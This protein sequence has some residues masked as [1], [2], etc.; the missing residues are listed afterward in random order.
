MDQKKKKK[1]GEKKNKQKSR[2]SQKRVE[3]IALY[4]K[5]WAWMTS[6][7]SNILLSP[8]VTALGLPS[9][10]RAGGMGAC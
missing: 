3:A 2:V 4:P 9:L 7:V 8:R 1:N 6:Q 5:N 10:F